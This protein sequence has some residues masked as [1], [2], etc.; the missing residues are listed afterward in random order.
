MCF[1]HHCGLV[2]IQLLIEDIQSLQIKYTFGPGIANNKYHYAAIRT[3]L[4]RNLG[5]CF[6]DIQDEVVAAVADH[7]PATE[8]EDISTPR[9]SKCLTFTRLVQITSRSRNNE[10]HMSDK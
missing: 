10:N 7:I 8:S 1:L 9:F 6:D 3:T 4:N 2:S 5:I